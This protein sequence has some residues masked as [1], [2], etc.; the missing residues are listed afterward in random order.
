[1]SSVMSPAARAGVRGPGAGGRAR[2]RR[3]RVTGD[4][5]GRA[6][7]GPGRQPGRRRPGGGVRRGR[8]HPRR[9]VPGHRR[10]GRAV[11]RAPRVRHAAG[12]VGHRRHRHR[13][14]DERPRAG[15]RDAVRRV[16]L[17]GVRAG[18]QPP[19]QDAQ[20]DQGAAGAAGGHPDPVRRR[21]RRR[22]APLR[23]LGGVLHAHPGAAGGGAGYPGRRLPAAAP[24]DQ[25][26]RPGRLP[27]AQAPLLV[28]G[29]RRADGGR[30]GDR[31]GG[32]AP[33]GP[34]RHPDR[35][36]RD[37]RHRAGSGRG[38]DRGRLG[39]R[40]HR[41]ALA[42]AA[43]RGDAGRVGVPHR[44]GASSCTRRRGSAATA[45]RWPPG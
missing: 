26:P 1:M 39:R 13:D 22:R 40:G 29:D 7:P 33:A 3:R 9:G 6:Q 16:R 35:V 4:Y 25:L 21:H 14:G 18:H 8:R 34:G 36:R 45:P 30:P 11:R 19:G 38:R 27:R 28:Q 44:P 37:G 15:G 20:P 12:R 31:P 32:R 17:P 2:A 41:P 43:G 23:L 42:V 10:A 24:G 5:G